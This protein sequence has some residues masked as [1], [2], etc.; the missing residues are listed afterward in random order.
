MLFT[1]STICHLCMTSIDRYVSLRSPLKYG[2]HSKDKRQT[3]L[4]IA[5]VWAISLCIAGPLFI[6]SMLDQREDG[7]DVVYKG[8]GPETQT[9]VVS[10]AVASFYL[11]LVIM[12]FMYALTVRALKRQLRE[13]SCLTVTNTT[14]S[15]DDSSNSHHHHHQQQQL[16][17]LMARSTSYDHSRLSPANSSV[18]VCSSSLNRSCCQISATEQRSGSSS[19]GIPVP[20]DDADSSY[21]SDIYVVNQT[22]SLDF[23]PG[24]RRFK[25]SYTDLPP[26]ADGGARLRPESN[27]L[28]HPKISHHRSSSSNSRSDY[29]I[30]SSSDSFAR[31]PTLDRRILSRSTRLQLAASGRGRRHGLEI[32]NPSLWTRGSRSG[33]L[34]VPDR[35]RRAVQVLGILFAFFVLF[36][37]PF[38]FV[39][40]L[41][42][43][44]ARCRFYISDKLISAFEWLQ[45][46]GS[47]VNPF[48]YHIFNPD[49]RHAFQ[50]LIRCRCTKY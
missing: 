24:K 34:S 41:N 32:Q 30:P 29:N 5:V 14:S 43:T 26:T 46:S 42:A 22:D 9:F 31:S 28:P 35:G 50:K 19:R 48:V 44:C 11:P 37:L 23:K 12:T 1:S 16:Q 38:F 20:T 15:K 17:Q 49:F 40:V 18:S 13:Q 21:V 39:Y 7:D 27:P 47:V 3:L 2:S 25:F 4:K 45:Y 10:A 36:Y 8:C 33:K 6:L